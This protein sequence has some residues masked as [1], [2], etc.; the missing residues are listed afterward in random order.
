MHMIGNGLKNAALAAG[1]LVVA[2]K[3]GQLIAGRMPAGLPSYALPAVMLLGG[4]YLGQRGGIMGKVGY[5]AA[6]NGAL[7]LLT[8]FVPQVDTNFSEY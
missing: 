6:V 2:E 3:A 1:G 4:A 5:G 7:H 8:A